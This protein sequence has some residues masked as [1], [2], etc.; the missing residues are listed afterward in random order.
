MRGSA[1]VSTNRDDAVFTIRINRDK[2]AQYREIAERENRTVTQQ[3]RAHIDE[4]I[5]RTRPEVAET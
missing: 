5:T 3:L 4:A 2:L 1:T